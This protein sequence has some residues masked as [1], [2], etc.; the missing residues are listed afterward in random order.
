VRRFSG[1]SLRGT[2][3]HPPFTFLAAGSGA[4]QIVLSEQ[5]PLDRGTGL[6]PIAPAFDGPSLAIAD[7]HG[8]PVPEL[9]DDW[10]AFD[11]A[12]TH[13]RGLS[14]LDA[15]PLLIEDLRARGLLFDEGTSSSRRDLCPHCET[16]L[17]P[18]AR[19]VWTVEVPGEPWVVSRDRVWGVPLPVWECT[20]CDHA[21]CIAGLDDLA[22]RTGLD[23]AQIDPHR[24]AVDRLVLPCEKCGG[25]MRRV[26]AVLDASLESAV[27]SNTSLPQSGPANLAIGVGDDRLG[28]L[29]DFAR[30]AALLG[31]DAAWQQALAIPERDPE[32]AWDL[33][34]HTP[35]DAVRWAAYTKTTPDQAEQSFLRPLW[36]LIVSLLDALEGQETVPGGA[37]GALLDRWAAARMHEA[38]A[39]VTQAL[40]DRNPL[41]AASEL[42]ALVGDLSAWYV[43]R[44]PGAGGELL[45]PLTLLLAPFLPHLA[46]AIHRQADRR[47]RTSVHLADWPVL[48]PA[49]ED[50]ALLAHMARVR[51]LAELGLRARAQAGIA[52]HQVLPGALV[53]LL[54][55][56]SWALQDLQ[57]SIRLLADALAVAQVKLAQSTAEYVGWRLALDP[58]RPVQREVSQADIEA[59][60]AELSADD[61]AR[62]A[63]QLRRGMSVGL[64]VSGLAITLLPDE[65]SISV[66]ARP[67]LAAAADSEHL[68]ALVVG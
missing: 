29:G 11:D 39:S 21:L 31:K 37:T 6:W 22:R 64:E 54:E 25:M 17:L 2:H 14:P 27:L 20:Q 44:R 12:V 26:S 51:H 15:E 47:S 41:R 48:D 53:G 33:A 52:Q 56:A 40:D 36:R 28:W 24:P 38:A 60:L 42:A 50:E 58:D 13:W 30:V 10:G 46:E 18:L 55:G 34:R 68:V 16:P 62:L 3:Y 4:G 5:V 49:W 43:P 32:A 66:Q 57:P 7:R 19:A 35:A 8:L 1:R 63:A 23:V 9:L 59:A 67:G 65:V 45:E 61:A